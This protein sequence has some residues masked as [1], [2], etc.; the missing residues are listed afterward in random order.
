VAVGVCNPTQWRNRPRFARGSLTF[1]CEAAD[2]RPPL[3]KNCPTS[4]AAAAVLPSSFFDRVSA[5]ARGWI[6]L[7]NATNP[8]PGKL[9]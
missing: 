3:S 8:I 2:T 4:Y 7:A 9:Y 1:G 5:F 6:R